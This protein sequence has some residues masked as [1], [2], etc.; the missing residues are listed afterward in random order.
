LCFG[1]VF[2]RIIAFHF[3]R[4]ARCVLKRGQIDAALGMGLVAYHLIQFSREALRGGVLFYAI[5]RTHGLSAAMFGA[6]GA[7]RGVIGV[8][9]DKAACYKRLCCRF[10]LATHHAV[11]L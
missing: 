6:I 4:A 2:C 10:N 1:L 7:A 3:W 11:M 9:I 5:A 8:P